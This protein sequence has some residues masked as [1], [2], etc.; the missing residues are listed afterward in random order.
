Q[1]LEGSLRAEASENFNSPVRRDFA[2]AVLSYDR[3]FNIPNTL[4]VLGEFFYNGIGERD[5][6]D[7]PKVILNPTDQAFL[8]KDYFGSGLTYEIT[9]LWKAEAYA[10]FNLDDGSVYAGPQISWQPWTDFELAL[11][12]QVFSGKAGTEYGPVKDLGFLQVQWFFNPV[13]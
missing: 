12:Y 4:Y 3:S 11:G 13:H 10:I 1:V 6:A 9:A 2:R 5:R 7:Y 8:G